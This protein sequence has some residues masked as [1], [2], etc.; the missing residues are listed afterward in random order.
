MVIL[1][2]FSYVQEQDVI[3]KSMN[4]R[5]SALRLMKRVGNSKKQITQNTVENIGSSL[6]K[7]KVVD[8]LAVMCSCEWIV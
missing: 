5:L 1:I 4:E 3:L 2:Q 7:T 8:G 6:Y